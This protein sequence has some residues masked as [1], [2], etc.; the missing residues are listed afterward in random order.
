MVGLR[1]DQTF[2]NNEA[3]YVPSLCGTENFNEEKSGLKNCIVI[4]SFE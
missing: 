3:L 1:Q 2:S 4:S